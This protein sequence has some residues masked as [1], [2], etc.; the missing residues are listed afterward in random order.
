MSDVLHSEMLADWPSFSLPGCSSL[1]D[2]ASLIFSLM[3]FSLA[4]SRSFWL[5]A[6]FSWSSV[7]ENF[8]SLTAAGCSAGRTDC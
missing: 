2:L 3:R 5:T 6:L 4:S 8:A 7:S 1:I